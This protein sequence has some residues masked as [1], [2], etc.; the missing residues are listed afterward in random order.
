MEKFEVYQTVFEMVGLIKESLSNPAAIK[1]SADEFEQQQ[2]RLQA[3]FAITNDIMDKHK[4]A[5]SKIHEANEK[6]AELEEEKVK[7]DNKHEIIQYLERK[8]KAE[9][10]ENQEEAKVLKAKQ[11]EI[12]DYEIS[13]NNRENS[14]ILRESAIAKENIDIEKRV[15]TLDRKENDLAEKERSLIEYERK[16]ME[17]ERA[18]AQIIAVAK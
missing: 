1:E 12:A 16:I 7:C 9:A 15:N 5:L 11:S 4:A 14:I 2:K 13:L 3:Q 8:N 6:L 17:K 10:Q 18:I